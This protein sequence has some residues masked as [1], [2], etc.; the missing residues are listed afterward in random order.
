MKTTIP[1]L[2][3]F[4]FFS[5]FVFAQIV[6]LPK[7]GASLTT[8]GF[9]GEISGTRTTKY[10]AGLLFGAGVEIGLNEKLSLVP[11]LLFHQKGWL[12]KKVSATQTD[13]KKYTLNY[14]EVP[15]MV[16][17]NFGGF[18]LPKFRGHFIHY[19]PK[20]S[21]YFFDCWKV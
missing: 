9:S 5:H 2:L 14:L 10:K 4:F 7:V 17:L 15:F 12:W 3:T 16:K 8:T 21:K 20:P 13:R 6:I 18:Y 1:L 19:T 11:E